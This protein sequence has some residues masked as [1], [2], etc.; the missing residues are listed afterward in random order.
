MTIERVENMAG[1]E[2]TDMT[3]YCV[4]YMAMIIWCQNESWL[5]IIHSIKNRIW[6]WQR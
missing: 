6:N 5:M 2:R 4:P 1:G 3:V